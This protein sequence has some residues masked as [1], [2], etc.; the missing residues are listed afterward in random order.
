MP[1]P[2][3]TN[4]LIIVAVGFAAP[5]VLGLAPKLRLPAVV[6]EI[7][8]GIVVGPSVLGWVEVDDAVEVVSVLGLAFLL[9]LAGLEID[10]ER[11]RGRVA[12]VAVAGFAISFAIALAINARV[13]SFT[14]SGPSRRV[15]LRT[16]DSSGT[17]TSSASRQK[18]R[19]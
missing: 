2:G 3:F 12:G 1:E 8:A 4:L 6:L 9:F 15:S 19:K 14:T 18:R 16:V 13:I 11:L 5:F 10:Y 7:V 17:R